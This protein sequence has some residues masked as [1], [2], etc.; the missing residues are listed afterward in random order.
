M[1]E[2]Y[3]LSGLGVD[4]RVFEQMNF[5]AFEPRF[6]R[7]LI[8][9]SSESLEHYSK[10]L[11]PQIRA[12]KPILIGLSFGGIIAIEIAQHIKVEKIILIASAKTRNEIPVYFRMIGKLNLLRIIPIGFLKSGN[13]ISNWFFGLQSVRDR[14]LLKQI[15]KDTD[16]VFLRWAIDQILNWKHKAI[17]MNVFHI[18]G[19]SDRILP[20]RNVSSDIQITGGG[21]FMTVNRAEE[22]SEALNI[23]LKKNCVYWP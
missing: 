15:L 8:P 17:P 2:V 10:R 7:W 21:H 22:V 14:Q 1:R 13:V 5:Y 16:I 4:Q 23:L 20:I 12:E 18:H 11:L 19:T 6:I 3:V 9:H